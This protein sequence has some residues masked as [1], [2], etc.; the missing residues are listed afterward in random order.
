MAA[1]LG[2]LGAALIWSVGMAF[3]SRAARALGPTLTLAWVMLIGLL[4]LA[5]VLPWTGGAHLSAAAIV[6]LALGGAGNVA[7]L[8]ILYHALRIGQ[9][10]V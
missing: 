4:A 2:G 10:G 9:M 7:G 8:L 1:V 5:L 6:W 3:A